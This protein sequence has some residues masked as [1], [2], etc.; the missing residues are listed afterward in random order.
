MNVCFL[1]QNFSVK[2]LAETFQIHLLLEHFDVW[3]AHIEERGIAEKY[4]VK[5][6]PPAQRPWEK[7]GLYS[8]RSVWRVEAHP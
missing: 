2:E 3:W 7:A 6:L 5:V 4:G 1:L 8:Y